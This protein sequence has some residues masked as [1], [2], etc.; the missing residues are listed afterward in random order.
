MGWEA[1]VVVMGEEEGAE[2]EEVV[3]MGVVEWAEE[4]EEVSHG[5][6]GRG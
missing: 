6:W 1:E 5:G 3:V 4:G 2:E